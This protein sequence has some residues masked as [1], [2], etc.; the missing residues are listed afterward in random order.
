MLAAISLAVAGNAG[1]WAAAFAIAFG[2][3]DITFYIFL[4]V[5]L[6]WPSSVLTWDILFLLP[7]PWVGPVLA[8]VLVSLA[9]IFAGI[10]HLRC[11]AFD[12]CVRIGPAHWIGM[13]LGA[14]IIVFAFAMDYR[15]IMAA[16]MPR[17]FHWSVFSV[18][19]LI[20]VASYAHAALERRSLTPSPPV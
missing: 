17:P 19:M 1:Q 14:A 15:N 7:V 11:E 16:R 4:K 9:M 13:L 5:L 10:W 12:Q 2:T 20:G 8:P 3:W 6:D 18:G